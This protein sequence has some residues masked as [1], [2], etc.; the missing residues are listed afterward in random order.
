MDVPPATVTRKPL[1]RRQRVAQ[2]VARHRLGV[3]G[4]VEDLVLRRARVL[5]AGDVAHRIAARFARRQSLGRQLTHDVFDNR[6]LHEVVLDVL[7]SR[8][9]AEAARIA[10][11]DAG[12]RPHLR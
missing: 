1:R 8:H 4:R 11:G 3:R 5:A 10:C 6:Q 9:V 12:Q 2:E 7:A